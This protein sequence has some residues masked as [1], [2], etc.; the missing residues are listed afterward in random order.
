MEWYNYY[1]I[2]I[3]YLIFMVLIGVVLFKKQETQEDFYVA[4]NKMNSGVLFATIFSTVVGANTYMGFSGMVYDDGF[5]MTW[6]L[7]AAGSAYFVLFY[8]SGKIRRIAENYE[9]F[10]LPD[11]MS[12][13][14]SDSTAMLTTI[15]SLVALIGGAGG[16]ILGIGIILNSVLGIDTTMAVIITS[17]VTII[18]TTLGGLMGVALT[19]WVQSI[20]MVLGLVLVIIFG[21][22]ALTPE[23]SWLF[24]IT[25]GHESLDR[26]LGD[27]F[28]SVT[29]NVTFF[30]VFAWFV[31][32]LPLN[33]ISQT[34]IQRVYSA[35][36]VATIQRISLLMVWF[37]ALF[38]AFG[39]A[40]VG[41]LGKALMPEIDNSETVFPILAMELINPWVGI[42][43]V[44]G[45]LG[46]CMST[47]DSNL[48]GA[49]IH[50]T[51][52]IY[53]KNEVR[54]GNKVNDKQA[55]KITRW[56]LVIIGILSTIAALMTPSIMELLLATQKI[57]AG[58]TFIPIM[59]GL[60]W[61]N[62]NT[63]GALT[64]MVLGGG[65]TLISQLMG[66]GID[67]VLI[68]I[69]FS[70]I[71]TIA[72]S[73]LSKVE[74]NKGELFQSK[75]ITKKDNIF[76]SIILLGYI[77]FLFAMNFIDV[78]PI[79]I[80]VT[81]IGLIISTVLLTIYIVPRKQKS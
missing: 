78:W 72:G 39:L 43:V 59:L 8:I 20:I 33:T 18:Y 40:L 21:L 51:R 79:L 77:G 60:L 10:T 45:I 12:L 36:N 19:D 71:G 27:D 32:F 13:R 57:F 67:P 16:S 14:Y 52:D 62:A 42:I 34:Q 29:D 28:M 5:S 65:S 26:V 37:V 47:I 63:I 44:T 73:S 70:L 61:K 74:S 25:H 54:K 23:N 22:Q 68:G 49:G 75:T 17:V 46:A 69:L 53:E 6:M 2:P 56:T 9:V 58:A 15:F 66:T 11:I 55:I 24:A 81:L 7:V 31:T 30:M 1:L 3:I 4:G 80:V 35:K 76:L 48:L 38:M 64:G 50:V 41:G